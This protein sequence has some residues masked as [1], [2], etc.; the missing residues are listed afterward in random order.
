M[1]FIWNVTRFK[2]EIEAKEHFVPVGVSSFEKHARKAN[3]ESYSK[4]ALNSFLQRYDKNKKVCVFVTQ[5]NTLHADVVNIQIQVT[6][7]NFWNEIGYVIS[8]LKTVT[9]L[10][11]GPWIILAINAMVNIVLVCVY[12]NLEIA[13]QMLIKITIRKMT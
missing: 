9:F 3:K 12:K 2:T 13:K 8:I 1:G 10:T 7:E 6:N 11:T 5:K 4:C